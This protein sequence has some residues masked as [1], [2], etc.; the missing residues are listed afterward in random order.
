MSKPASKSIFENAESVE[1]AGKAIVKL[2]EDP[3]RIKKTGK[4]V[5]VSDLA[6]EY[7]FTDDDGDIHDMRSLKNIL[8]L[9]GSK[10]ANFIPEFVRVPLILMHY[11]SNKF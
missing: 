4:I 7:K 9:R 2:A 1:F 3:Q 10:F 6:T 5:L 8:K 11:Q